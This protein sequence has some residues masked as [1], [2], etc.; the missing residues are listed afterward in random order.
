MELLGQID[1]NRAGFEDANR[2]GATPV[3]KSRDLRVRI[4][5]DEAA[6]ELIAVSYFD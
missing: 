2:F 5:R 3:Q 4:N 1:Q 6:T